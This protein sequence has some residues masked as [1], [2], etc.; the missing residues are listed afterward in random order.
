VALSACQD[1]NVTGEFDEKK[2]VV[3]LTARGQLDV[4]TCANRLAARFSDLRTDALQV[5]RR[6]AERVLFKRNCCIVWIGRISRV[7]G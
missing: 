4:L 3:T 2:R 5:S 6:I 7:V 1:G